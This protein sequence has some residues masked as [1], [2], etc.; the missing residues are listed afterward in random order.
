M[1]AQETYKAV[2]FG[3]NVIGSGTEIELHFANGGYQDVVVLEAVENGQTIT[4]TY[5]KGRETE[6]PIP[7]RFVDEDVSDET[8]VGDVP[9]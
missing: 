8:A 6:E 4:R 9:N 2:L 3:P 1:S 5:R 7:Y